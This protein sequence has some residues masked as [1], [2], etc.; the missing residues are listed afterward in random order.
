LESRSPLFIG[1][2]LP[3]RPQ[4]CLAEFVPRRLEGGV[5]DVRVGLGGL[6]V[7]LV[8][9]DGFADECD[10]DTTR[11]G[12]GDPA[13]PWRLAGPDR[14]PG[15]PATKHVADQRTPRLIEHAGLFVAAGLAV[16][17]LIE[18]DDTERAVEVLGFVDESERVD[19]IDDA[20]SRLPV[21]AKDVEATREREGAG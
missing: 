13:V 7:L 18:R 4:V 8:P 14:R 2:S 10:E 5:G 1:T 12:A 6:D 20:G 19:I 9:G 3:A 15:T 11:F 21:I 17:H 16:Q